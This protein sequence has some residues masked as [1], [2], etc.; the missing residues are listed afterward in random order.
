MT[1]VA[2]EAGVSLMTVSRVVNNKSE[3]SSKTREKVLEIIDHLGYRPSGIARG[4]VTQHTRT[5]GIVVPDISNPFFAKLVRGAEQEAYSSGYSVFLCNT[6][7]DP[8]REIAVMQSLEE[9]RIDGLILCASRLDEEQLNKVVHWFPSVVLLFRQSEDG[10][11]SVILTDDQAGGLMATHH[12]VRAGHERIGFVAGPS[13][14]YSSKGRLAGYKAAMLSSSL[15][16][17]SDHILHCP[18]TV[19][20][21]YLA[22]LELLEKN[23]DLTSLICF[24]DLVAVGVM[25]AAEELRRQI[26]TDLAIIGFDDIPLAALVTPAL[27]TCRIPQYELGSK[28]MLMLLDQVD[29]GNM[30]P[31]KELIR[32]ELIIRD[33]SP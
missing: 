9:K 32:P 10:G 2:R 4:L 6:D 25:Q 12:L 19:H 18:P 17:N 3:V 5:F 7:E 23:P 27:S 29:A 31:K 11:E 14:S 26:P 28:A 30:N 15:A 21:G 13:R 33:S 24:N 8:N 20:G 16:L 1:D 22:G